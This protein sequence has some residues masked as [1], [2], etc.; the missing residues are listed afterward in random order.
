MS[1]HKLLNRAL[2]IMDMKRIQDENKPLYIENISGLKVKR[3][4]NKSMVYSDRHRGNWFKPEYDLTELQIAQDTDSYIYKAIQKKVNKL[5]LAGWEFVGKDVEIVNYIK[6]R[7]KEIELVSGVPF[8]MLLIQTAQDLA[9]Y[10]NCMWVKVRDVE[11]STGVIRPHLNKEL[12][13]IAGYFILPFETLWFKIKPNGEIKKVMQLMHNTGKSQEFA[14]ENIVHFY[15]NKKPGFAMGTP[16]L[17]PV[18]EDVALLRRLEE[19]VEAMIDGNLHPLFHY[20]VGTDSHPE[21]YGPDGVKETDVVRQ[22]IE[23]MPSGGI[24][25]SDHRHKIE[26]I[27]SEGK[28]LNVTEYLDYF[29]K[30]VFSGLGVTPVDMGEGD[31]AN[32]ATASSLS[33]SAIQDV[34]ALQKNMK[35]FIDTFIINELLIEGGYGDVLVDPERT[36]EIKFGTVDKEERSKLENQT[37]QL[38][39]NKL[40]N[41]EE[42]RKRLGER[43]LAEEDRETSYFTLYE[44]PLAMLKL[45]SNP[46][47]A[48]SQALAES[49]TSSITNKQIEKANKEQVKQSNAKL[50]SPGNPTNN[51]APNTSAN[52]A[53]PGNQH[54]SRTAPKFVKNLA[55]ASNYVI[56][57]IDSDETAVKDYL[58]ASEKNMNLAIYDTVEALHNCDKNDIEKIIN[59]FRNKIKRGNYE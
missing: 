14:P 49:S 7:I 50:G 59:D 19:N 34:E 17:L 8:D 4:D 52:V 44:E 18:L 38:W 35:L 40:I 11:A 9:R 30:R 21:R 26:S 57:N 20:T 46:M 28:A 22:T 13:P 6:K 33:K 54:G 41:E 10:S 25:V 15:T 48:P 1:K 32:S 47:S 3:I 29:K 2:Q 53:R 45:A 43:P 51:K 31:S 5:V 37:I 56:D 42:A 55:E 27:G 39:L 24:F 23:Y 36:V 12:D 16:E 58:N